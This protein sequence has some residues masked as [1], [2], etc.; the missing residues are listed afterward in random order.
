MSFV[1]GYEIES[2]PFVGKTALPALACF[3]T[4]VQDQRAACGVCLLRPLMASATCPLCPQ[5]GLQHLSGT[6]SPG[7]AEGI[8]PTWLFLRIVPGI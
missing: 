1:Y 4:V 6:S 7:T 5:G 8:S 2:A 3:C